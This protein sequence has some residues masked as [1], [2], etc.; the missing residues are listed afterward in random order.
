M[1]DIYMLNENKV[2]CKLYIQ[3]RNEGY[4]YIYMLNENKVSCKLYIQ[5]KN[6]GYIYAK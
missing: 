1:K 2:S 4:I 3:D 5:G 6:E